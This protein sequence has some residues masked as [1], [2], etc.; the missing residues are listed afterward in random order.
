MV[1]EFLVDEAGKTD[2][3]KVQI[4]WEEC[5]AELPGENPAGED[6][7]LS[8]F[9][10]ELEELCREDDQE[11]VPEPD[12]ADEWKT[13]DWATVFERAV[14]CLS[15]RS[16]DFRVARYLALALAGIDGL[17]GMRDG[18]RFLVEIQ[19][20]WWELLFPTPEK[21]KD[22]KTGKRILDAALRGREFD[23]VL[24]HYRDLAATKLKES[25]DRDV[26]RTLDLVG[27][28]L[29]ELHVAEVFTKEKYGDHY[30]CSPMIEAFRSALKDGIEP[31]RET[32]AGMVKAKRQA[33]E[34]EIA[35]QEAE[36]AARQEAAKREEEEQRAQRESIRR[37]QIVI[38]SLGL[39]R[40]SDLAADDDA[41]ALVVHVG[42]IARR[43]RRV[44]P[45][46]LAGY[47]LPLYA[48]W[49][50]ELNGSQEQS[51]PPPEF[52]P[53]L[54]EAASREDWQRVIVLTLQAVVQPWGRNWLDLGYHLAQA[55]A[56]EGNGLRDVLDAIE[57]LV[58]ER[59]R[60]GDG[61]P[62]DTFLDGTPHV[63]EKA[64]EWLE[65]LKSRSMEAGQTG[66]NAGFSFDLRERLA[67]L[68]AA[69]PEEAAAIMQE[70]VAHTA[71]RRARFLWS[72]EMAEQLADRGQ[73]LLAMSICRWL[74]DEIE[75]RDLEEWEDVGVLTRVY[76]CACR[77][78][79]GTT[80]VDEIV[81]D[82]A[83]IAFERLCRLAPAKAMKR[84]T[85]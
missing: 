33:E 18:L 34:D 46:Q 55:V 16:K 82:S 72:L 11:A 77:G 56:A 6:L 76:D 79:D 1:K 5:L 29:D 52:Q 63:G 54:E 19:K 31:L 22:S 9:Y 21:I 67:A 27:E 58:V 40:N 43:L 80:S 65:L 13:A 84:V 50:T 4:P 32:V 20:R 47:L 75:R 2:A 66:E 61:W 85:T 57:G 37:E 59:A 42:S 14:D 7:L 26:E 45:D 78:L 48:S 10:G 62:E 64:R 17:A 44:A 51:S 70:G 83:R 68:E 36:K 28:L 8:G 81:D 24:G 35:R 41:A 74:M 69:A 15:H 25:E 60:H 23:L 38:E 49:Y 3:W 39:D 53:F 12:S 73:G 30:D 71:S